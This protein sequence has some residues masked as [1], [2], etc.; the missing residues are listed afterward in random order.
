MLF[1]KYFKKYKLFYDVNCVQDKITNNQG[2]GFEKE[3]DGTRNFRTI[4]HGYKYNVGGG[5]NYY[6]RKYKDLIRIHYRW[7][8]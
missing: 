4:L 6:H 2:N 7:S 5:N 1:K 8:K 3:Y